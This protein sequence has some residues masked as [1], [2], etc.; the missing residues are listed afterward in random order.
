[1]VNMDLPGSRLFNQ[2]VVSIT[3]DSLASSTYSLYLCC[4]LP[5]PPQLLC[6]PSPTSPIVYSL[7][8]RLPIVLPLPPTPPIAD[9]VC[10]T[11]GGRLCF[12]HD[13]V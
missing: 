12:W 4:L 11:A 9:C 6:T 10:V 3:L 1:M 7:P 5:P 8:H 13:P 2:R